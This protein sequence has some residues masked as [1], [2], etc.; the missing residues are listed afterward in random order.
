MCSA[1]ARTPCETT[2]PATPCAERRV[3]LSEELGGATLLYVISAIRLEEAPTTTAAGFNLDRLDS[4]P[5]STT[6]SANC[7][8]FNP[9]FRSTLDPSHVGVDNALSGLVGIASA[10]LDDQGECPDTS[11][12]CLSAII[13]ERI[14]QGAMLF[15][16]EVSRVQSLANDPAVSVAIHQATLADGTPPELGGDS[17]L[18]ADQI[19]LRDRRLGLSEEA[20]IVHGRLQATFRSLEL[21]IG[22]GLPLP[23]PTLD[24]VEMRFDIDERSLARGQLGARITVDAADAHAPSG[25]GGDLLVSG[26][27]GTS[28]FETL[29][30]LRP[31]AIDPIVCTSISVGYLL[32][33][34]RAALPPP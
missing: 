27:F 33:G 34:V 4:G 12:G 32:E 17:R 28:L 1:G 20:S 24:D 25:P 10:L 26:F 22:M 3:E 9:D 21:P 30:D 23:A 14:D 13:Q 18:A 16:V 11:D 19:F 6:V 29:A 31:S 8:E 5:G 2:R 7:E 15:L